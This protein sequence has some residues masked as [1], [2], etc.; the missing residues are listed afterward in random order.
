M[1]FG[2]SLRTVLAWLAVAAT[3]VASVPRVAC[4]CP[5]DKPATGRGD[6]CL[7][8][9]TS[10]SAQTG[11]RSPKHCCKQSRPTGGQPVSTISSPRCHTALVDTTDATVVPPDDSTNGFVI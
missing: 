2:K 5:G 10:L 8:E 6:C 4:A 9:L 3:P 7:K 1:R 11:D